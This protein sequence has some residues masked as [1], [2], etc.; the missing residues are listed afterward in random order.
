MNINPFVKIKCSS[1]GNEELV[2]YASTAKPAKRC[3]V[4]DEVLYNSTGGHCKTLNHKVTKDQATD[5]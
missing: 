3:M 2:Y 1:C 4:C 5:E